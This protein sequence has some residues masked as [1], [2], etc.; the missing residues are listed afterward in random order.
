MTGENR[1]VFV[2]PMYNAAEYVAK[3][4]HSICGQSY[5]NWKLIIIDDVSTHDHAIKC[6]E[7]IKSFKNIYDQKYGSKIFEFWNT[8]KKWEV[9]N[10]LAGIKMCEDNDIICRIDADDWLTDLD[11]LAIISSVYDSTKCDALWTAHR[12]GYSDKNISASMPENVDPYKYPWVSSHLKTFKKYLL[13]NVNAENF[14]NEKGEFVKRAGDQA[15]YLP[16]LHN[17][18]KRVFLPRVLYHYTINDIPETYQTDDAKFQ[19]SEA[20][21]IRSRG[22]VK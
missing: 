14:K 7:I 1:F 5:E 18:K 4:L 11:A 15:V 17:A 8:E 20:E 2:T 12:W 10:V 6:K 19:K 3:M 16:A 22:F 9:E 21:F 13:N